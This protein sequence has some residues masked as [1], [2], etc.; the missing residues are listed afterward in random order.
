MMKTTSVMAMV[1]R[2]RVYSIHAL[3]KDSALTGAQ[4]CQ[5]SSCLIWQCLFGSGN[6]QRSAI[7]QY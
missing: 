1:A 4:L 7:K 6:E 5:G 3:T 2:C